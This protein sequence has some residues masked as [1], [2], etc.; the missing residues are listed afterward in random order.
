MA[1]AG[2]RS[3]IRIAL[4]LALLVAFIGLV[5]ELLPPYFRYLEFQRS[6]E[7]I[8]ADPVS[9]ERP[10]AATSAAV[11]NEAARLG[12]PLRLGQVRVE[13]I[14]GRVRVEALYS[15]RVDLAIYTVDLHFRPRAGA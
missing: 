14:D 12:V 3:K 5:A 4:A 15:V 6:L 2:G 1:E 8:V 11:V 9:R 13:K 7:R 10:V